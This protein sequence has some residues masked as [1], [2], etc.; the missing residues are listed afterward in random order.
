MFGYHSKVIS[1]LIFRIKQKNVASFLTYSDYYAPDLP[2]YSAMKP[3]FL[4]ETPVRFSIIILMFVLLLFWFVFVFFCCQLSSVTVL[5]FLY[6]LSELVMLSLQPLFTHECFLEC[7]TSRLC[8]NQ[9]TE[10]IT[11]TRLF[12]ASSAFITQNY[13]WK[14]KPRQKIF[15]QLVGISSFPLYIKSIFILFVLP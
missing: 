4:S 13:G 9:N 8:L 12:D 14:S 11:Q 10:W 2:V 6:L 7:W 15:Q 5:L 1:K 3:V